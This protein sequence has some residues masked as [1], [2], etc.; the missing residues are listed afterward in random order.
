MEDAKKYIKSTMF[1][2][3][4]TSTLLVACGLACKL[5]VFI[6]VFRFNLSIDGN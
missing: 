3:L 2:S 5:F 4:A 1:S 6:I